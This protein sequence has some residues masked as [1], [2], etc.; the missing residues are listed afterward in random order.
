MMARSTGY[1][2]KSNMAKAE[3]HNQDSAEA[4]DAISQ[5]VNA[6][7]TDKNTSMTLTNT[8]VQ[9]CKE[10]TEVNTKLAAALGKIANLQ[11]AKD[12]HYFWL[13]GSNSNHPSL[14][15]KNKNQGHV[16]DATEQDKN[17]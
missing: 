14:H 7:T 9:L 12:P 1:Y 10:I 11:E 3:Y 16:Y 17:V 4:L 13:C 5:L 6:A 2:V 8:N 15:C